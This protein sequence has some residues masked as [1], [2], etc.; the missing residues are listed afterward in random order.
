MRPTG[1]AM[2]IEGFSKK[3]LIS[4]LEIIEGANV[5]ATERDIGRLLL[6]AMDLLRA[7]YSICGLGKVSCGE[8][9][10]VVKII[11]GNYPEDW[12]D[13][14][15]SEQLYR[16]DPVI[17]RHARFSVT[18][19][20][21]DIFKTCNDHSSRLLIRQ[22]A[23]FGLRYGVS[24]GIFLPRREEIGI[25]SFAAKKD[26]FNDRHK[27]IMDIITLHLNNALVNMVEE[28]AVYRVEE[29]FAADRL[30]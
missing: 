7:D 16:I 14:Y 11:N 28:K 12:L 30:I 3:E 9:K 8:L 17:K 22:A 5:C 29:P 25:F 13:R 27:R 2:S 23:D 6:R 20:W 19:L 1:T 21:S 15:T 26:R 24:S 18:Q 4:I 10:E